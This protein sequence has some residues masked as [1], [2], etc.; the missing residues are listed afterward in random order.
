MGGWAQ[1]VVSGNHDFVDPKDPDPRIRGA[2]IQD[3]LTNA[4]LLNDKSALVDFRGQQLQLYGMP[5]QPSVRS[6][7][8]NQ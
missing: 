4:V 8:P 1:F 3:L 7:V 2:A 6:L 5:W